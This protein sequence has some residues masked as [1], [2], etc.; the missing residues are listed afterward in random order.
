MS[1]DVKEGILIVI[2][3]ILI[4]GCFIKIVKL[5]KMRSQNM[6]GFDFPNFVPLDNSSSLYDIEF[7][8]TEGIFAKAMSLEGF[9]ISKWHSNLV[10]SKLNYYTGIL[11]LE[12]GDKQQAGE[13]I[14]SLIFGLDNHSIHFRP[15]L[16]G[17]EMRYFRG[18][19]SKKL[20]KLIFLNSTNIVSWFPE[21]IHSE[22][23]E[24]E[25][26]LSFKNWNLIAFEFEL[27]IV[28]PDTP[29]KDEVISFLEISDRIMKKL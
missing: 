26:K 28:I 1:S 7:L 12:K 10:N 24:L 19:L 6:I 23:I 22:I 11:Y 18:I 3:F 9:H 2:S 13:A 25:S 20:S 21:K 4:F 16:A 14:L 5:R 29:S 8:F 27:I 15:Y 17:P